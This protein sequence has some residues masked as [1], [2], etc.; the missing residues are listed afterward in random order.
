MHDSKSDVNDAVLMSFRRVMFSS[1]ASVCGD[2]TGGV[3]TILDLTQSNIPL[4]ELEDFR[5]DFGWETGNVF[6]VALVVEDFGF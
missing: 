2:G 3:A 1:E 5:M 6:W 4:F